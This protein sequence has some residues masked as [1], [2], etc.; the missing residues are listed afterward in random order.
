MNKLNNSNQL[1]EKN[2][3]WY[4]KSVNLIWNILKK[5]SDIKDIENTK[6]ARTK[7]REITIHIF[8]NL[9]KENWINININFSDT[10]K[11]N[12]ENEYMALLAY[13]IIWEINNENLPQLFLGN[14]NSWWIE[15]LSA[16]RI[17]PIDTTIQLKDILTWLPWIK[18]TNPIIFKRISEILKILQIESIDTKEESKYRKNKIEK[19]IEKW[20]RVYIFPEWTRVAWREIW[21]FHTS[22]YKSA[23]EKIMSWGWNKTIWIITTYSDESFPST[24][25]ETIFIWK[26]IY[27]WNID[28]T[29]DFIDA[30]LFNNIKD[31]NEEVEKIISN[32]LF[33]KINKSFIIK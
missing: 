22:L 20:E 9:F 33:K 6:E 31:F 14:H 30:S 19:T 13:I 17:V 8:N 12:F 29:I 7:A 25:E 11:E 16:Y 18:N 5:I 32:N 24:F 10:A 23:Y 3:L 15:A 27:S 21:K 26:S 2:K 28:F 1:I 4:I